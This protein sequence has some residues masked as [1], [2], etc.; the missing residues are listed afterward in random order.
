MMN[1]RKYNIGGAGGNA[2]VDMAS[3]ML[4]LP[5]SCS[6][7]S[8]RSAGQGCCLHLLLII[9]MIS[10]MSSVALNKR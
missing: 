2:T 6:P 1:R 7:H 9:L 3:L 8:S 4:E 5:R 10:Y